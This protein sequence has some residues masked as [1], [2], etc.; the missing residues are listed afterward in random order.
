MPDFPHPSLNSDEEALL[1]Y[2]ETHQPVPF[3]YRALA[4]QFNQSVR[5]IQQ[6]VSKC[7]EAGYLRIH[8]LPNLGGCLV[9]P[10]SS[11]LDFQPF[12]ETD[13]LAIKEQQLFEYIQANQPVSYRVKELCGALSFSEREIRMLLHRLIEKEQLEKVAIPGLGHCLQAPTVPSTASERA[14][15]LI[16]SME[17]KVSPQGRFKAFLRRLKRLRSSQTLY[18][19]DTENVPP[20]CLNAGLPAL[21]KGDH[22]RLILSQHTRSYDQKLNVQSCAASF[23]YSF[24]EVVGKNALDFVII[25]EATR[26]LSNHPDQKLCIVSSDKGFDSALAYLCNVYQL[27]AHWACRIPDLTGVRN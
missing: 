17:V 27:P 9:I 7:L 26:I 5:A 1:R 11:S 19:I 15:S 13:Y 23:D 24:Q 21:N 2:V 10:D 22:V 12:Q 16:P 3:C 18:L 25:A 20:I 4:A 8:P 14:P 6:L